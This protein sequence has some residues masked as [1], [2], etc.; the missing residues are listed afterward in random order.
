MHT[1][2][3]ISP[4]PRLSL[5]HPLTNFKKTVNPHKKSLN[6][7]LDGVFLRKYLM[8]LLKLGKEDH[9]NQGDWCFRL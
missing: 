3:I 7:A 1:I 2:S 8:K 5:N 6:K 9:Y 4:P